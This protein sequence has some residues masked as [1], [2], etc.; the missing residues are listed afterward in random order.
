[1]GGVLSG[2][3]L[4]AP[5]VPPLS[6]PKA[7]EQCALL[8]EGVCDSW[9]ECRFRSFIARLGLPFVSVSKRRGDPFAV[10]FFASNDDRRTLY[11]FLHGCHLAGSV[12]SLK[13]YVQHDLPVGR[14][15]VEADIAKFA[16][17]ER[18]TVEDR[19][20]PL[21]HLSSEKRLETKLRSFK[22]FW[23]VSD[24]VI[25]EAPP[26]SVFHVTLQLLVGFDEAGKVAIGFNR[27]SRAN[28]IIVAADKHLGVPQAIASL[29]VRFTC[30]LSESLFPPYDGNSLTGKWR[31][32]IIRGSEEIMVAIVTF[33][34]LPLAEVQAMTSLF[35]Q[36]V[37]SLYW[38]K[39][40][41]APIDSNSPNQ[42]LAGHSFITEK[43][44]DLSFSIAPF[45]PFPSNMSGSHSM[46]RRIAELL[47]LDQATILVDMACGI[48]L[49]CVSLARFVKRAVGIDQN[50]RM[51][52][53]ARKNAEVNKITNSYFV[54]GTCEQ[55]LADLTHHI[56]A[57]ERVACLL[58]VMNPTPAVA[59]LHA[60]RACERAATFV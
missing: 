19:L 40:D 42:V 2:L 13:P 33:G 34:G 49:A 15:A 5:A 59:T 44:A 48:G 57:N 41:Q 51:V 6:D 38:V 30:F 56:A 54:H 26:D 50:E 20:F 55:I 22:E 46:F 11:T 29:I 7:D 36:S 35:E 9:P 58:D 3:G 53:M 25:H 45:S 14:F 18:E 39:T 27:S 23:G 17:V 28:T 52:N 12:F 60:L 32:L 10:V 31:G 37:H 21:G 8:V 4:S 1:M 47:S 24:V 43:V 16:S